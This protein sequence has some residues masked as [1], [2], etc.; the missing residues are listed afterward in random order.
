MRGL[1]TLQDRNGD[2]GSVNVSGLSLNVLARYLQFYGIG[3]ETIDGGSENLT[4][5]SGKEKAAR[6]I[7]AHHVYSRIDFSGLK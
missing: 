2:G 3:S 5:Q 1:P 6:E 4:I 7:L